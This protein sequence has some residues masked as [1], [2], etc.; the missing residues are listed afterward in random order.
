MQAVG[1]GVGASLVPRWATL[2]ALRSGQVAEVPGLGGAMP[3]AR[4]TLL[5]RA[6]DAD[7]PDLQ[8]LTGA[9]RDR[10]AALGVSSGS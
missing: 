9:L 10:A 7:R 8:G 2:E 5:T 4:W 6:A 3:S 1:L